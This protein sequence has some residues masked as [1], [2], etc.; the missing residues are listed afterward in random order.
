MIWT[1]FAHKILRNSIHLPFN[2]FTAYLVDALRF[3]DWIELFSVKKK[4]N[5]FQLICKIFIKKI[6]F[7]EPKFNLILIIFN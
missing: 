4:E 5:F 3:C 7:L 1:D 2:Y 6:G